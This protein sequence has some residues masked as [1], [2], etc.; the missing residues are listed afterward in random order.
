MN[1][2][3]LVCD[4]DPVHRD[5][6]RAT[7]APHGHRV[8]E[9]DDG[10][11]LVE[12]AEAVRP[13]LVILDLRMPTSGVDVLRELRSV[14]DLADTPVLVLTGAARAVDKSGAFEAG[15]DR[16]LL[17]PFSPKELAANVA[18]LVAP[19]ARLAVVR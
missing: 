12:A 7:L 19:P 16:F 5:L 13:D 15:A 17:K 2:A 3:I 18:E 4:D 9:V 6:I 10:D 14:P 8:H 11:T 1:A